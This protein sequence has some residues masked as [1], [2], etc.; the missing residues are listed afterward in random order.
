MTNEFMSSIAGALV[1]SAKLLPGECDVSGAPTVF[2]CCCC[3]SARNNFFIYRG[4]ALGFASSPICF[5]ATEVKVER[6]AQTPVYV[7]VRNPMFLRMKSLAF[8]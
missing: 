7:P 4:P 3:L 1:K 8:R 5:L 2:F 6:F